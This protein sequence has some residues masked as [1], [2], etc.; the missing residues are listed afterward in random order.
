MRDSRPDELW[1]AR[2]KAAEAS[3]DAALVRVGVLE[4]A[5]HH[6]VY[7][8]API[9]CRIC[10]EARA[11]LSSP[12][13]HEPDPYESLR[14]LPTMT[15]GVAPPPHEKRTIVPVWGCNK[16]HEHQTFDAAQ[17]CSND[18]KPPPHDGEGAP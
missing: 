12:P 18:G 1:M 10:A 8:H 15:T 4:A 5:L 11:A 7:F 6:A 9:R 16:G 17:N 13:P 14:T 3:R 2:V